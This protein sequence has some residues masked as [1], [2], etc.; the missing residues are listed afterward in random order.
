MFLKLHCLLQL[1][2]SQPAL[3]ESQRGKARESIK[4]RKKQ[5][6]RKAKRVRAI[7]DKKSKEAS[8]EEDSEDEDEPEGS[9]SSEQV[10]I[11]NVRHIYK[12]SCSIM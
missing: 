11:R 5:L 12:I 6:Q 10:R 8:G 3:T 9:V 2:N 1:V 7:R 4:K